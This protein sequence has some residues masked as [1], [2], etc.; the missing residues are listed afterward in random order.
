MTVYHFSGPA[1]ALPTLIEYE[2]DRFQHLQYDE[3]QFKSEAGAIL[4][5]YAKSAS[6]P[7]MKLDEALHETAY[8]QHTYRHTVIGYL[9]DIKAM[10]SGFAYSRE[11]FARYYTP[12]NAT[13]II[14]GDFDK[15]DTLARV[16]KAYGGWKGKLTPA[17][18]PTEP[19]QTAARHAHVDWKTPTLPRLALAWHTPQA[20]DL[21]A[22]AVQDL[23]TAYLFG[24]TS[25][26]YQDL[27][28]K[29]Q[30]VDSM[31]PL[32]DGLRD[33]GLFGVLLR[34]KKASD[35]AEVERTVLSEL[36][37]LAGG[38][39]DAQRLES[40]RSHLKYER[41]LGY[42]TA[43]HI[44]LAL[45]GN[46]APTGELDYINKEAARADR[47]KPAELTAFAKRWLTEANRT[48]VTLTTAGASPEGAR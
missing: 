1:K 9:A 5:E 16:T 45:A 15:K 8:A 35:V 41:I 4:G 38:H 32:Y 13:V 25:P 31:H 26:L 48:T 2:A 47:V 23:L 34:V 18:I 44:A 12:D 39:V 19:A 17:A 22:S 27:V 3:E 24:N 20:S 7:E 28:I 46:T 21:G 11:F 29:R 6:N 14:V 36:Q 33:P 42:D 40:V 30:L 43:D 37:Q 10:P